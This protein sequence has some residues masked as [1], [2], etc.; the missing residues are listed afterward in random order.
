MLFLKYNLTKG[1]GV[2]NFVSKRTVF[3]NNTFL[4]LVVVVNDN[5]LTYL[6]K[7]HNSEYLFSIMKLTTIIDS[8]KA[9]KHFSTD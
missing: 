5:L 1:D 2:W 7:N 3:I 6:T 8:E 9:I 4:E